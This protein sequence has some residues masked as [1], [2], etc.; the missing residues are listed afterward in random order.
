MT[1][2]DTASPMHALIHAS[3]TPVA[4]ANAPVTPEPVSHLW[5]QHGSENNLKGREEISPHLGAYVNQ[6][7]NKTKKRKAPPHPSAVCESPAIRERQE[8]NYPHNSLSTFTKS[9]EK[10]TLS[11]E[12]LHPKKCLEET[13]QLAKSFRRRK[14]R[15]RIITPYEYHQVSNETESLQSEC[16]ETH[17]GTETNTDTD[18]DRPSSQVT[19]NTDRFNN[20]SVERMCMYCSEY[21]P[22]RHSFKVYQGSSPALGSRHQTMN[23]SYDHLN[24][25]SSYDSG[26][27]ARKQK[28][29]TG[30]NQLSNFVFNETSL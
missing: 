10:I 28:N 12:R 17:F 24:V 19:N 14:S 3:V 29:H 21:L 13:T 11:T 15:E 6:N 4:Q 20:A 5:Y 30:Q 9:Q 1:D 18:I 7:V 23:R 27:V 26:I 25:D 8:K 16:L 22:R 2:S